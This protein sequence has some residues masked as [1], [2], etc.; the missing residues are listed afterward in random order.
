MKLSA[1]MSGSGSGSGS[2]YGMSIAPQ[3]IGN[4]L[5]LGLNSVPVS[6]TPSAGFTTMLD[7]TGPG[8]IQFLRIGA[9]PSGTR[10]HSI[11]ITIDSEVIVNQTF[12]IGLTNWPIIEGPT[13]NIP[14]PIKYTSSFKVEYSS[15]TSPS[16][17]A[18]VAYQ[19]FRTK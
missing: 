16:F 12:N 8:V 11:R 4:T 19:S 18:N 15:P 6:F 9:I 13:A 14:V 5:I 10:A 2:Q 3:D 1:L 7:L 17:T